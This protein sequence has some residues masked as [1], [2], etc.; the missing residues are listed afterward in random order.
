MHPCLT[1]ALARERHAELL[2]RQ[3]FRESSADLPRSRRAPQ[4]TGSAPVHP[5]RTG[6]GARHGRHAPMT[7]IPGDRHS[8]EPRSGDARPGRARP[9]RGGGTR[10]GRPRPW[11]S[12]RADPGDGGRPGDGRRTRGRP[13]G[14]G[15][16]SSS[17]SAPGLGLDDPDVPPAEAVTG[18]QPWEWPV[19]LD[20]VGERLH[21]GVWANAVDARG[22]RPGPVGGA[23]PTWR[24]A[25]G[26]RAAEGGGPTS[27]CP[28]GRPAFCDGGPLDAALAGRVGMA[29]PP[30][31]ARARDARAPGRQRPG[32]R[33][34]GRRPAG[35]VAAPGA[36]ARIIAPAGSGKTRVLTE[37]ARLLLGGGDCRPMPWPWWPTTCGPP[38]R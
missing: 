23:G 35:A 16:R 2:H 28:T 7:P 34:A 8:G 33:D 32:R 25:S 29:C 10:W 38:T 18:R 11:S 26:P 9:S 37:R 4:T 12:C 19:D 15:A 3:R 22:R 14:S 30:D 13:G 31:L 1:E 24:A 17:S 20:L 6:L 36:G 21:H 27:C 5:S